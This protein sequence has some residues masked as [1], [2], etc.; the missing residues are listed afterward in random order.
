MI[1]G[2]C[3]VW[4]DE[5]LIRAKEYGCDCVEPPLFLAAKESVE[6]LKK[7]REICDKAGLKIVTFNGMLT[8]NMPL[9]GEKDTRGPLEEYLTDAFEKASVLGG[10]II[11]LGCGSQ[12]TVP[13]GMDRETAEER[14]LSVL[15]DVVLPAAENWGLTVA[16]EELRREECDF[17]NSANEARGIVKKAGRDSLKLH[18]DYFHT[19]L[20]GG[21]LEEIEGYGKD[22]A[23]VHLS[24]IK[25]FREF[26]KKTDVEEMAAL[27]T[28]LEKA[29]YQ[30]AVTFEGVVPGDFWE[31]LKEA[32]WTVKA[33]GF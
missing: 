20:G 21:T 14:F 22:I 26:P 18:I 10:K 15:N 8:G 33:A 25:H 12:R 5:S 7:T 19:V 28:A 9:L 16:L 23:H 17:I 3:G 31:T 2:T 27:R 13:D 29:G 30:G 11:V 6:K 32:V 1:I 4:G 24:S